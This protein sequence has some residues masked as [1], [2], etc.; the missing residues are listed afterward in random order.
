[1]SK[2][3]KKRL[4]TAAELAFYRSKAEDGSYIGK[5]QLAAVF[6]ALDAATARA[7]HAEA[8]SES[9][10][11]EYESDRS[12]LGGVLLE[13]EQY[14][15]GIQDQQEYDDEQ[16][17]R[18]VV[19]ALVGVREHCPDCGVSIGEK[20]KP[21]CDIERCPACGF[22]FLSCGCD[23]ED[24]EDLPRIPW[25]GEFPGKAECR[26]YGFYAKMVPGSGW[27]SCP[28]DDPEATEHLN[29]LYSECVWDA[30]VQK[31]ILP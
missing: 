20:H 7:E 31:F 23:E 8:R 17:G 18:N 27:V 12:A 11:R 9:L 5:N 22:Q 4:P 29:R 25:T 1:M 3:V 19:R 10:H 16:Y 24:L 26:E 2:Q 21:H 15:P 14:V 6:V 28:K 13:A 30:S